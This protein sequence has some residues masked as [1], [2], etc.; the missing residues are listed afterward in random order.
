MSKLDKLNAMIELGKL[1]IY[2]NDEIKCEGKCIE[3]YVLKEGDKYICIE[4]SSS[5]FFQC[6]KEYTIVK[7]SRKTGIE[8]DIGV[9]NT[10]TY[11]K[12]E[13]VETKSKNKFNVGDTF[14]LDRAMSGYT[15]TEEGII[16]NITPTHCEFKL[17]GHK[18]DRCSNK[19]IFY[20]H[21]VKVPSTYERVH[22]IQND[23]DKMH[24]GVE[25][26][27][28][29]ITGKIQT[30][31]YNTDR[32]ILADKYGS[33]SGWIDIERLELVPTNNKP[34]DNFCKTMENYCSCVKPTIKKVTTTLMGNSNSKNTF[35][36]CTSCKKEK[37]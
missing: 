25:V 20:N 34:V 28:D 16:L 26:H 18:I 2:N 30:R 21:M 36:Y 35:N 19:S 23:K 29:G 6:G 12:F 15:T 13:K 11:S 31:C 32:V 17:I 4:D 27:F 10:M 24:V 7:N 9:I 37:R 8:D 22:G 1:G 14:K 3:D 5:Y 33:L